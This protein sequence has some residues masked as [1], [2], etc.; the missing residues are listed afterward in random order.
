MSVISNVYLN[1]NKKRSSESVAKLRVI[2][3][4]NMKHKK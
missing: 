2:S 3:L 4:K 1:N